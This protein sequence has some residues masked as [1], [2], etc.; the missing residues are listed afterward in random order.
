MS[1]TLLPAV[2]AGLNLISTAL[3]LAGYVAIRSGNR[4]VH[5]WLMACA[6]VT[7]SVFLVC[8]VAHKLMFEARSIGLEAGVLRWVYLY[9]ILVP[10]VLLAMVMVPMI[11][12]LL[13]RAYNRRWDSHRRLAR[14][15]WP[16]WM[17]VSVTGVVIYVLLYHVFPA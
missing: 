15:T 3:L 13:W 9:V 8:Y 10:H 7:S 5:G 1:P 17:Y 14:Y 11:L 6:F 12:T 16:I 2:N 4:R